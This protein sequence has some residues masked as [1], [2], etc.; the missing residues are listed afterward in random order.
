[1]GRIITFVLSHLATLLLGVALGMYLL[2]II[3]AS[4]PP[5]PAQ[6]Q[7]L[8]E[9][10]RYT[11]EF[12]RELADS[13]LLHWGEGT[14]AVDTGA[15]ALVGRLAPGPDYRLYLS[16]RFVQTE[17]EFMRLKSEMVEVGPVRS[18]DNFLVPV[19]AGIDVDGYRAVIVWCE[20]FGQFITAAR[21]R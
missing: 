7:A 1:M 14:V 5:E 2:P 20:R 21:Y 13:D 17:A 12:R 11:G 3:I 18:F 19:P 8:V 6:L 9:Q 16:P 4:A 15:I 10:A